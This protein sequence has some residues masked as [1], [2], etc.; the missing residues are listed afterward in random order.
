ME[1]FKVCERE[2]KT[3]TFSKEGLSLQATKVDPAQAR[4]NDARDWIT[5]TVSTL[6]E[7]CEAFEA[8]VESL[9]GG[10]GVGGGG[11]SKGGGGGGG[12]RRGKAKAIPPRVTHLEASADRHRAHVA[13]LEQLLRLLD[14]EA[15]E[16]E[17]V[18]GV[19]ELVD[20]Y[21]A[22]NQGGSEEAADRASATMTPD[23]FS[24]PDDLYEGLL[25]R[26]DAVE[27]ALP[28][29]PSA[30]ALKAH[31]G[32]DKGGARPPRRWPPRAPPAPPRAVAALAAALRRRLLPR[33]A[34]A[35]SKAAAVAAAAKQ[36]LAASGVIRRRRDQGTTTTTLPQRRPWS[37]GPQP[38]APS[39]L[40]LLRSRGKAGSTPRALWR[41]GLLLLL[42]PLLL[43]LPR[44]RRRRG[45]RRLGPGSPQRRRRPPPRP[46]PAREGRRE[47]RRRPWERQRHPPRELCRG[48]RSEGRGRRHC[49]RTFDGSGSRFGAGGGNDGGGG[50]TKA[51]FVVFLLR[52]HRSPTAA[53]AAAAAA[54]S[55]LVDP[56]PDRPLRAPRG[57][58]VAAH[59]LRAALDPD[60]GRLVVVADPAAEEGAQRRRRGRSGSADG[61]ASSPT[62][63]SASGDGGAASSGGPIVVPASYPATRLPVLDN[64]ALFERLDTEALFF[65]FYHQPGHPPAVPGRPGAQAPVMAVPQG[66]RRL[67]PEARGAQGRRR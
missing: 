12:G 49:K 17:D 65:A 14:N 13:R 34:A 66:A 48:R 47:G 56:V 40:L 54:P 57:A 55:D 67:V 16:V 28:L 30:V 3:K 21:L 44:R 62:S 52:R 61:S 24:E 59:G 11:D 4:R 33:R 36:Q 38:L 23:E 51:F 18:E 5:A 58:P 53:A 25:E 60:A 42:P 46:L 64:P 32:D 27:A 26:L 41:P 31:K 37:E 22:R 1:R 63:P 29:V 19:R 20:D 7:E 9:G 10:S 8:E 45:R 35:A 6:E 43:L 2:S 39:C 15:I 50:N